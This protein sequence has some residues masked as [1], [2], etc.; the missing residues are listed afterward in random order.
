VKGKIAAVVGAAF[1]VLAAEAKLAQRRIRSIDF[2]PP[3]DPTGWYGRDGVGSPVTIAVLGDSSAAGYGLELAAETPGAVLADLVAK[4]TGRP[5]HLR[6]LAVTGARSRDLMHQV[7]QAIAHDAGVA[8]ILVGANDV[9]RITRPSRSVDH[10]EAAVKRLRDSGIEV[11]VGLCPD[12]GA[13]RPILQPLRHV[14]KAWSRALASEQAVRMS[15]LG[16]R[17]VPLADVLGD[18]FVARPGIFF[19]ADKFHPSA[20]GYAAVADVL[21]PATLAAIDGL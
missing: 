11:V 7:R 3:P 17:T 5:V 21:L 2:P 8:V 4:H 13:I 10:L 20:V 9:V 1:G 15:H 12:F 6:D 16:V 18:D 19:G 14:A